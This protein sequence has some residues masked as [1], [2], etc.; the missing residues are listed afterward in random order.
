VSETEERIAEAESLGELVNGHPENLSVALPRLLEM[1]AEEI[2][3]A[4]L[5]EVIYALGHAWDERA[6]L[7]TLPFAS[8]PDDEVRLAVAHAAPGG[9]TTRGAEERC[10]AVLIALSHDEWD[11]VR[12]WATFGLG[13]ILHLDSAEIRDAL[14]DRLDD[15]HIDTRHEAVVG[16]A[17]RKDPRAFQP[18]LD[19]LTA[20]TLYYL[21]FDAAAALAD[22][23][24]AQ[25]L[26]RV[27][28]E[29]NLD[30]VR[31]DILEQ[32]LR[33]C[34]TGQDEIPPLD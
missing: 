13:T 30:S 1:L 6:C 2:D 5:I 4:V 9:L 12:D 27:G 28:D 23:R 22:P 31:T 18:T 25:A 8:H 17:E 21:A 10:A 11:E 26:R 15:E 24:L 20:P 19:M 33:A 3:P 32:A 29:Y 14:A 34:T 16:L 7:A